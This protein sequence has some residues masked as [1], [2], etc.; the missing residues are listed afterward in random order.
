MCENV[1]PFYKYLNN[2][3]P[4]SLQGCLACRTYPP[5]KSYSAWLNAKEHCNSYDNNLRWAIC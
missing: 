4:N 5:W 2:V 3:E 1:S